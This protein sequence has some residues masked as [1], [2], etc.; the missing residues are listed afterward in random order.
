M[1][2]STDYKTLKKNLPEPRDRLDRVENAVGTGMPDINFCSEGVE[3]WIEQKSPTE[4][5]RAT[6]KLF[7]SNHKVSQDQ[8]NW[9]KRQMTARGNAYFL[10]ATDKRWMLISGEHADDINGMTVD[11]LL[12]VAIWSTNK[13]V[14]DKQK[15]KQLR[16]A[17]SAKML[18]TI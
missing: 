5:K 6:T 16:S 8:M 13:P 17:L 10:I 12:D 9:F 11:E 14:K 7:G 1:A 4:P 3:C 15:W 2:E 18:T